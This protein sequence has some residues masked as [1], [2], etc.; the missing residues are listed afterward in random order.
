M[1]DALKILIA[2]ASAFVVMFILAKLMGKKQIAQLSFIDYAIGITVGSIAAEMATE[3]E[4]PLYHYIIAMAVFLVLDIL[5][6]FLSRKLPFKKLLVGKPIVIIYEG[7]LIYKNLKKSKL[8]LNDLLGLIRNQ[9]YFDLSEIQYAILETNGQ[10]SVVPIGAE[11]PLVAK[12]MPEKIEEPKLPNYLVVDGNISYS[13]LNELNKDVD[14]LL[15][16]MQIDKKQL[17][18]VLIASFNDDTK[19]VD[20]QFKE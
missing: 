3:L 1:H 14:W 10:L 6:T 11:R 18:D 12:D 16:Q 7:N 8:D 19:S 5:V 20:V 4:Q 15:E 9:G 17:K 2:A 13:G